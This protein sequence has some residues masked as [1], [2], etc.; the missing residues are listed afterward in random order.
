MRQLPLALFAIL[1]V[2]QRTRDLKDFS[3]LT[4][5]TTYTLQPS[6]KVTASASEEVKM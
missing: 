5:V 3:W 4:C 1:N 6:S 2:F